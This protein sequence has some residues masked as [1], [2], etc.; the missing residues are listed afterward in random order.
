MSFSSLAGVLICSVIFILFY[1]S[2][3][4]PASFTFIY[5]A[6]TKLPYKEHSYR[7]NIK[8]VGNEY[9]CYI[10]YTP[11]YRGRFISDYTP[12]I[13]HDAEKGKIFICWTGK[14]IY[15]EQAKTLCRNW[16]DATQTY[17]DTGIPAPG[18]EKNKNCY[19]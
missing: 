13:Y 18:F 2:T 10:A 19:F 11:D 16:A 3:K 17:I 1:K 9:R 4:E 5:S 14:I 6:K 12:H 8:K 15:P 7:F